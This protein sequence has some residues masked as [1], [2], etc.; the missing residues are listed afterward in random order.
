M[1][2]TIFIICFGSTIVNSL[3]HVNDGLP[4]KNQR[5]LAQKADRRF[6]HF[7]F[8]KNGQGG[9]CQCPNGKKYIVSAAKGMMC[10][11]LGCI[12]GKLLSCSYG[13]LHKPEYKKFINTGVHCKPNKL[14]K[15]EKYFG[16]LKKNKVLK[17]GTWR[18]KES[19][20]K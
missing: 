7:M 6:K 5:V 3:S 4:I 13:F 14:P 18:F 17:G 19:K 11:V 2:F 12:G 20:K 10:K 15:I 9:V 8:E 16:K 1:L